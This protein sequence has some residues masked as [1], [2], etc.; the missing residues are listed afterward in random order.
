MDQPIAG[1]QLLDAAEELFYARGIQAVGM[2]EVRAAAG[3]SLKRLYQLH[4]SKEQLVEA[5]LERRDLRWRGSLAAHVDTVT[6]PAG[7]ILAVFDWMRAWFEEPGFRGCAWINAHGELGATSPGVARQARRHKQAFRDY[8]GG[9]VADAGLPPST[10][11][12]L[13]LLAEGA[14]AVGGISHTSTPAVQAKDAAR[15]LIAAAS[16]T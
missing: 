16:T 14:M 3:I 6:D 10:A 15:V 2:D 13:V 1:T 5:F 11:D 8:L 7:R 12:H 4:P 9:L